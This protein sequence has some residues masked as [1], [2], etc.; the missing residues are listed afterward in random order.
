M[1]SLTGNTSGTDNRS[2]GE[3]AVSGAVASILRTGQQLI[4]KDVDA[5][6][7]IEI[8]PGYQFSVFINQDLSIGAYEYSN[9]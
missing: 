1:Q 6:P 8:T 2:P 9:E 7:T 3:E 5:Q 4:A